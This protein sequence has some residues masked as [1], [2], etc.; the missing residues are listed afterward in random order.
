M[1]YANDQ[2]Q[3]TRTKILTTASAA[4]RKKGIDASGIAALMADAGLTNGAFYAHFPSKEALVAEAVVLALDETRSALAASARLGDGFNAILDHY[5][6]P[7]HV[8][9]PEHGCAVAALGS[10]FGRLPQASRE[11]INKAVEAIVM[12][13]ADTLPDTLEDRGRTARAIFGLMVGTIQLARAS[14]PILIPDILASGAAGAR[15][16]ASQH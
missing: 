11:A 9:H 2:K 10:E 3:K 16:L 7:G 6:V 13:I 14:D 4:F 15:L 5:L 12:T 8:L 1:R